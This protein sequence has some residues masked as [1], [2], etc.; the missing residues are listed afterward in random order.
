MCVCVVYVYMQITFA[1]LYVCIHI[2]PVLAKHCVQ[3]IYMG[4]DF[5]SDFLEEKSFTLS[6]GGLLSTGQHGH[7]CIIFCW[8]AHHQLLSW[9]RRHLQWLP[10]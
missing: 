2:V 4:D 9:S 8:K 5:K 10:S 3:G 1:H 6:L 7:W